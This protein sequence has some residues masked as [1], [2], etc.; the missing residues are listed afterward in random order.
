MPKPP[1]PEE[2]IFAQALEINSASERAVFLDR[3]CRDN[4]ALRAEVEALMRA[5][6][7]AGDLLD[8]PDP[9]AATVVFGSGK[10][11]WLTI[12]RLTFGHQ[13]VRSLLSAVPARK[14]SLLRSTAANPHGRRFRA[15]P[16][17]PSQRDGTRRTRA[18][19][20]VAIRQSFLKM[21]FAE[22]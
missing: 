1:L 5:D 14:T 3:V 11:M 9:P 21:E 20:R 17:P 22:V 15:F 19:R 13:G 6:A 2:S 7:W 12:P 10:Q 16:S 8:L 4:P 18:N